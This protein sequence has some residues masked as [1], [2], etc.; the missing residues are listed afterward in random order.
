[1]LVKDFYKDLYK[2]Y[3]KKIENDVENHLIKSLDSNVKVLKNI[4]EMLNSN[5]RNYRESQLRG[6]LVAIYKKF[7]NK[8]SYSTLSNSIR[9]FVDKYCPVEMAKQDV[10][11]FMTYFLDREYILQIE[12]GWYKSY[13]INKTFIRKYKLYNISKKSTTEHVSKENT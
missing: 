2:K 10:E 8:P 12:D 9:R 4:D 7:G 11:L 1:M 13:E 5:I 6:L 3:Q